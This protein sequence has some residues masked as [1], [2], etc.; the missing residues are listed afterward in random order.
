MLHRLAKEFGRREEPILAAH[1]LSLWQYMVLDTLASGPAGT[2]AGLAARIGHDKTRLI[3]ILDELQDLGLIDRFPDPDDR[4]NRVVSLTAD[5]RQR[6]SACR[7]DIRA[8]ERRALTALD[9]A[10]RAALVSGLIALSEGVS[11]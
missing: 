4:R 2:Q 3:G 7:R 11:Q 5:G 9:S 8:M 10:T 6:L 1:D